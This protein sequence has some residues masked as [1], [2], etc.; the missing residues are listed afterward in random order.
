PTQTLQASATLRSRIASLVTEAN[1]ADKMF[2]NDAN[3]E[4]APGFGIVNVRLVSA[5]LWRGSGA[6]LTVGA[7]NVFDRKYISSVS[8]NASG[9]KF[10]EPG[11]ERAYFVGITLVAAARR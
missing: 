3:S 5:A 8:V 6:E 10:Y 7:Q 9:G 4:R 1:F 11:S 2:V